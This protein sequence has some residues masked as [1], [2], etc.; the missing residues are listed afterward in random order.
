MHG[1]ESELQNRESNAVSALKTKNKARSRCSLVRVFFACGVQLLSL[2]NIVVQDVFSVK[3]QYAKWRN[4]NTKFAFC[5]IFLVLCGLRKFQK[6]GIMHMVE[7]WFC[8]SANFFA[9][10]SN[11]A[12][13][14]RK[15]A[16]YLFSINV[17][18]SCI[19]NHGATVL[20]HKPAFVQGV[21]Q[22][23]KRRPCPL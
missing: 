9:R 10:R 8:R 19:S 13:F 5:T 2:K 22:H 6:N 15:A 16:F 23:E 18:T 17:E 20:P 7:S 4:L 12:L 1:T 11:F 14:V 21:P 3:C